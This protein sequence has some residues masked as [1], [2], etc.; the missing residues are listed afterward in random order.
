MIATAIL[1]LGLVSVLALFPAAIHTGKQVMDTSSAVVVAESVAEA[2]REG[3][4]NQLRA[5][6]G[7]QGTNNYFI[8]QHDGVNDRV[9]NDRRLEKP[10]GDYYILL[11][12]FPPRGGGTFSGA[13][14][15][16]KAFRRGKVFVYPET[17]PLANGNGDPLLADNDGDDFEGEF[18]SGRGFKDI[19]VEKVYKLGQLFPGLDE[20]GEDVLADQQIEPL[21]QYSFAFAVRVSYYDANVTPSTGSQYEPGNVLYNFH[22]MVFR[23]FF[24][25]EPG[26]RSKHQEPVFEINF[27][28]AR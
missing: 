1:T 20:E 28:V 17:D 22:I 6:D 11:P 7:S 23:N 4:R 15:R 9:P 19:K 24:A 10:R 18:S 25:P 14:R 26:R 8:F 3:M 2:I 5:I 21:K 16:M 27:E 13:G 12:R